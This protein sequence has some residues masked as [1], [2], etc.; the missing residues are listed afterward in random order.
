VTK[1][2]KN[3]AASIKQ[4]LLNVARA[5]HEEFEQV[6]VRYGVERLLCRLAASQHRNDFLL[7]GAMLFLAWEGMPHRITRDVDLLGFGD[8]SVARMTSVVRDLC[9]L[10]LPDADGLVFDAGSIQADTIRTVE[11][12]GGV[13]LRVE[14]KLGNAV[15][16]IQ[17][18]V[19]FGDAVTPKPEEIEFPTLLNFPKPKLR[20]YPVETVIAEKTLAIVELGLANSRMKDYFDLLHLAR[21]RSFEGAMLAKALRATADRRGVVIPIEETAGLSSAFGQDDTKRTQWSAFI[22]RTTLATEWGDLGPVV[23]ELAVF[24]VPVVDAASKAKTPAMQWR[25]R[26]PWSP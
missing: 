21:T 2:P 10:T 24:L 16:R 5:N 25:P 6:L 15:I 26:G 18:D 19:G 3:I 13:R 8:D 14:A 11:E 7:K 22:K 9:N 12:Y 17:I 1:P 20:S 23:A 4:R